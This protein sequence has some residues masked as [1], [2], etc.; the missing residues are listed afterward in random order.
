MERLFRV[1]FN[2][3]TLHF[4]CHD[5]PVDRLNRR[6]SVTVILFFTM[7]V[8][9]AQY[10]GDPIRCWCP[11]QFTDSHKGYTNTICWVSNTYY[12]PFEDQI[13]LQKDP[14]TEI[15]YYQWVPIILMFQALLC[16]L[17][18]ILWSFICRKSGF[19]FANF[20]DAAAAGQRTP[21]LDNREKTLR[22]MVYQLD[23]FLTTRANRLSDLNSQRPLA[24]ALTRLQNGSYLTLGYLCVKLLYVANAICQ[25]YVLDLFLGTDFHFYGIDVV[26]RF[27]SGDDWAAS[28]RFPR[29]T[30]CDFI[31]RHQVATHR[32]I[33][34]C[35]LPINLFNEKIF[36]LLWFW[37]VTVAAVTAL[38]FVKWTWRSLFWRQMT[39]YVRREMSSLPDEKHD[40]AADALDS[41]T[42]RSLCRDGVFI[43]HLLRD[44][45]GSMIAAEVLGGLWAR[46][47]AQ[48]MP[49]PSPINGGVIPHREDTDT[50]SLPRKPKE[51]A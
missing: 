41:F 40:D 39:T 12:V 35:V 23:R 27:L 22:Y 2:V 26:R 19:S 46:H 16:Y 13:P 50:G 29:V 51:I 36:I 4:R 7:I 38:S 42:N 28:E 9:T 21:Y 18:C 20:I 34:Q 5:D 49:P 3:T 14:E 31:V 1:M 43:L 32:Y 10:V 30:L 48:K 17:P 8:S 11:A 25:L 6:Y 44:N 45:M 47:C 15:N 33:V 37:L 24:N